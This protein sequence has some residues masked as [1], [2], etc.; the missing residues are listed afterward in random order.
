VLRGYAQFSTNALPVALPVD[1]PIMNVLS[2]SVL[3]LP[4]PAWVMIIAFLV[5][6]FVA[7]KTAYGRS[8]FA[9]GCNA[10]AARLAGIKVKR[11]RIILFATMGLLAAISGVLLAARLGSGNA[12]AATG[13]EF[14]VIAAEV[15]G[16]TAMSGGRGS[17]LGNGLVLLGVNSFLQDVVRG[18]I[19]VAAVLL[20]VTLS[21]RRGANQEE[22]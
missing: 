12:G 2:S 7:R 11:V 19:I 8:V 5:F 3:G 4:S 22:S 21:R 17:L 9:I 14:D 20:N 18:V 10:G 1:D 6:A 15:I 13:L 16:G